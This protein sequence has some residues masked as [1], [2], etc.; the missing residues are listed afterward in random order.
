MNL[1]NDEPFGLVGYPPG[2]RRMPPKPGYTPTNRFGGTVGKLVAFEACAE[3]FERC[4][5][6][7]NHCEDCPARGDG[8]MTLWEKIVCERSATGQLSCRQFPVIQKRLEE[9]A[10]PMSGQPRISPERQR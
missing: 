2:I 8:C 3:L 1:R 4:S 5:A 6:A 10:P 7:H 9:L